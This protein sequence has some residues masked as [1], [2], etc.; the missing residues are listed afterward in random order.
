MNSD[1]THGRFRAKVVEGDEEFERL[2]DRSRIAIGTDEFLQKRDAPAGKRRMCCRWA[3][4]PPPA[5][6]VP[7]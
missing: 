4:E 5:S 6:N 7:S 1:V 3:A 2:M